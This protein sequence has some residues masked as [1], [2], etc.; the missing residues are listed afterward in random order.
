MRKNDYMQPGWF[1]DL[2]WDL[3]GLSLLGGMSLALLGGVVGFML[4]R[5]W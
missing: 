4:G 2:P 1:D 5:V 3:M